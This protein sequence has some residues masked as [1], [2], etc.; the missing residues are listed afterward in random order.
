MFNL[1]RPH[2]SVALVAFAFAAALLAHC[3]EM[4]LPFFGTALST[5][6]VVYGWNVHPAVGV[7]TFVAAAIAL[8]FAFLAST[9]LVIVAT[10]ALSLLAARTNYGWWGFWLALASYRCWVGGPQMALWVIPESGILLWLKL[11]EPFSRTTRS[12]PPFPPLSSLWPSNPELDWITPWIHAWEM[13]ARPTVQLVV[14]ALLGLINKVAFT[15]SEAVKTIIWA[16]TE[17]YAWCPQW[18]LARFE[19]SSEEFF[20]RR[21]AERLPAEVLYRQREEAQRKMDE[22]RRRERLLE[23]ERRR[24]SRCSSIFGPF[25]TYSVV[26]TTGSDE[27]T[28][29]IKRGS[30]VMQ[31]ERRWRRL[32]TPDVAETSLVPYSQP[33]PLQ[34]SPLTE[35]PAEVPAIPSP[36]PPA[37]AIIPSLPPVPVAPAQN[38]PEVQK[39]VE[40]ILI[41]DPNPS[42]VLTSP[43][44]ETADQTIEFVTQHEPTSRDVEVP[45][46]SPNEPVYQ[47][48]AKDKPSEKSSDEKMMDE[49]IFLLEGFQI[50]SERED[51]PTS[52]DCLKW[53]SGH[54]VTAPHPARF[55]PEPAPSSIPPVRPADPTVPELSTPPP[56]SPFMP[57][58]DVACVTTVRLPAK[59]VFGIPSTA[60]PAH[61]E[62]TAPPTIAPIS[63]RLRRA[64]L[65]VS[66]GSTFDAP[67]M[68]STTVSESTRAPTDDVSTFSGAPALLAPAPAPALSPSVVS[69]SVPDADT[70]VSMVPDFTFSGHVLPAPPAMPVVLPTADAFAFSGTSPYIPSAVPAAGILATQNVPTAASFTFSGYPLPS[71]PTAAP[72]GGPFIFGDTSPAFLP[73]APATGDL[74]I[75]TASD[76]SLS[77]QNLPSLFTPDPHTQPVP[78]LVQDEEPKP[79]EYSEQPQRLSAPT[80][81]LFTFS[82]ASPSVLPPAPEAGGVANLT[83]SFSGL[84]LPSISFPDPPPRAAPAPEQNEAVEWDSN[85][86]LT[87]YEDEDIERLFGPAPTVFTFGAMNPPPVA[88][89]A[90][91]AT[92]GFAVPPTTFTFSGLPNAVLP[93]IPFP[94]PAPQAAA[95]QN[96]D[97]EVESEFSEYDEEELQRLFFEIGG[98]VVNEPAAG[99]PQIPSEYPEL[100]EAFLNLPQAADGQGQED[101]SAFTD[102]ERRALDRILFGEEDVELDYEGELEPVPVPVPAPVSAPV[103]APAPVLVPAPAPAPPSQN[104]VISGEDDVELDYEGESESEPEFEDVPIPL[105]AQLSLPQNAAAGEA[106]SYP[107]SDSDED[108]NPRPAKRRV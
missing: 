44:C 107:D 60:G 106:P 80:A 82:A 86:E 93:S 108:P 7:W 92:P 61:F 3:T 19:R 90:D 79:T 54:F 66:S 40:P 13:C 67:P 94:D 22:Q 36:P 41:P 104:R 78:A 105:P 46:K 88:P 58:T 30:R 85:S 83:F 69:I 9:R 57:P 32:A 63:T 64:A 15:T 87:L 71:M 50:K 14:A 75:P 37:I 72:T 91:L 8:S 28:L 25:A 65:R 70:D 42:I 97:D 51:E 100:D 68:T 27:V 49:L 10:A 77:G 96:A 5:V 53:I 56:Q 26:S 17:S 59:P 21:R 101:L 45:A 103:L 2:H 89:A 33:P 38:T 29:T 24:A 102:D 35:V 81:N 12:R 4:L 20:A 34:I 48:E 47:Y 95:Q 43:S 76:F 73:T 39:S 74:T 84:N 6:A 31:V 99:E 16:F 11:C 62:P 23:I 18:R 1:L 52:T 55:I 98:E